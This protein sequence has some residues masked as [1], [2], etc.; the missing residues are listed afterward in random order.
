MSDWASAVRDVS[1]L[2]ARLDEA[3][4]L[5]ETYFEPQKKRLQLAHEAM[6]RSPLEEKH[7]I[8]DAIRADL[9][10]FDTEERYRTAN[11]RR[12]QMGYLTS[13]IPLVYGKLL[14]KYEKRIKEYN[15][16]GATQR[17]S[18]FRFTAIPRRG[19]KSESLGQFLAAATKH[20]PEPEVLLMSAAKRSAGK[21]SGLMGTVLKYLRQLGVDEFEVCNDEEVFFR[22]GGYLKKIRAVPSG[23]NT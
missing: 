2:C 3:K 1:R 20:I 22:V 9:D 12:V 18:P 17:I 7:R 23:K 8:M 16:V 4:T 21:N 11:Q 6:N 5:R 14:K 10:S 15:R 13:A 19:G